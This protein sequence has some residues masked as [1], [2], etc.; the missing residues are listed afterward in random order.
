MRVVVAMDK[1][2]GTLT[3]GQACEA[4]ARGVRG[5]GHD[6]ILAPMS[7]GGEGFLESLGG[8]N[9]TT[10]VTGP[11]GAAVSADWRLTEGRAVIE[12]ARASGLALIDGPPDALAAT[13]RGTGELIAEA[14]RAGAREIWVGVG[15]TGCTDGGAGAMGA[16]AAWLAPDG[17]GLPARIVALT[18]VTTRFVDAARDFAPQKGAS[19]TDVA[20]LTAR[21]QRLA[22]DYE[23]RFGRRIDALD[24]SGAGGG[25]AGGLAAIGG[26]I[27]SGFDAVADAARL[28][29]LLAAADLVVTGEGRFD[30]GSL[31]G[32]VVGGVLGLARAAH[33][34]AVVI[35]AQA[36]ADA[37]A[38]AGR[39]AA[40]GGEQA[41]VHSLTD[42][43]GA[44]RAWRQPAAALTELAARLCRTG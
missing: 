5:A 11:L 14:L 33:V 44:E 38:A 28:E 29:S 25:L 36:A 15:G 30:S 43:F 6:V 21:L 19:P 34:R 39:E 40:A 18:D 10:T 32:K 4:V 31:R 23:R 12:S 20:R 42:E 17:P 8:P 13:S 27:T 2:R 3:A 37:D 41:A 7:D 26:E 22:D 1:F 16:L 9:R 35:A 24:G